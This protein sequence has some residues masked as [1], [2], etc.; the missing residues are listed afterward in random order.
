M[1]LA[2]TQE[3]LLVV[4]YFHS[5]FKCLASTRQERK[6]AIFSRLKIWIL[7]LLLCF[8]ALAS[9]LYKVAR[10][11]G[12]VQPSKVHEILGVTEA[13]TTSAG[14]SGHV[15]QERGKLSAGSMKQVIKIETRKYQITW[16]NHSLRNARKVNKLS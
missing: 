12:S 3:D 5:F 2:F 4:S 10:E 6:E 1:P 11:R 13:E 9:I 16:S 14:T 15:T 8:K 7:T